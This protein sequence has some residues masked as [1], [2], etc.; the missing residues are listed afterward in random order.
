MV[1]VGHWCNMNWGTLKRNPVQSIHL[2]QLKL[3]QFSVSLEELVK[4]Y[5][6]YALF[7][8][9]PSLHQL[10]PA[11]RKI[12]FRIWDRGREQLSSLLASCT[13]WIW[14]G[15]C[16]MVLPLPRCDDFSYYC[17]KMLTDFS[18]LC[19]PCCILLHILQWW[20]QRWQLCV[21]MCKQEIETRCWVCTSQVPDLH[22]FQ[23][24]QRKRKHC[25]PYR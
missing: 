14:A 19:W 17:W 4:Q 9:L 10:H 5:C 21:L 6:C 20:Q 25:E 22:L 23:K 2:Q 3:I 24:R 1:A 13:S 18:L 16:L 15:D 12:L 8:S 7:S 11:H